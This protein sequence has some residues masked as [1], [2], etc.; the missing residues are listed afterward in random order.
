MDLIWQQLQQQDSRDED[1]H[2]EDEELASFAT[3][4]GGMA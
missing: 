2:I 3:K 1:F 4:K